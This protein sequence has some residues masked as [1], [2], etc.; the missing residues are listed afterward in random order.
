M[1]TIVDIVPLDCPSIECSPAEMEDVYR[2]MIRDNELR[3]ILVD[4]LPVGCHLTVSHNG[5]NWGEVY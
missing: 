2:G 4:G 5:T 3:E 1:L